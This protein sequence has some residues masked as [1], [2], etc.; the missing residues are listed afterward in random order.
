M[1]P[2]RSSR[3]SRKEQLGRTVWATG[4]ACRVTWARGVG[5]LGLGSTSGP[6][7]QASCGSWAICA[8]SPGRPGHQRGRT[9]PAQ[10]DSRFIQTAQPTV[11]A[12]QASRPVQLAGL[13]RT[14]RR[15]R[16]PAGPSSRA[17]HTASWDSGATWPS[18]TC[19]AS[20]AFRAIQPPGPTVQP[21]RRRPIPP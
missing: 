7:N 10:P 3:N 19:R 4:P 12:S 8:F 14:S 17:G 2:G 18:R 15:A 11:P 1:T 16:L 5:P 6:S 13:D 21:C 20:T 9:E